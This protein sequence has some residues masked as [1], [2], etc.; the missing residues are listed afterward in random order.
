[1]RLWRY[2]KNKFIWVN[3]KD[4][5][6]SEITRLV[7]LAFHLLQGENDVEARA[8]L[9]RALQHES[10]IANPKLLKWILASLW[11]T[12]EQTEDYQDSTKFFSD[13]LVQNPNRAL[14]LR[15]RAGSHWYGGRLHEAIADYTRAL[16]LKP[17]DGSALSGRGQVLMERGEFGRALDDPNRTPEAIDAV[18]SAHAN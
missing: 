14:A 2:F 8:L 18:E 6:H 11:K 17:N 1:M 10:K 9:L 15:L 7:G 5:V 4:P 12:W 16:E 3:N 13:F